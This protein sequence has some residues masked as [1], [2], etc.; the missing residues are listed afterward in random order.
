MK[1]A[2]QALLDAIEREMSQQTPAD[3]E[4]LRRMQGNLRKLI[5]S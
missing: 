1:E 4:W 3:Q 5:A 2:A